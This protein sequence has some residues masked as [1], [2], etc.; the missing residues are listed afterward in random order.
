MSLAEKVRKFTWGLLSSLTMHGVP[1]MLGIWDQG[2]VGGL[3]SRVDWGL[4][5]R[6]L[7]SHNKLSAFQYDH[8]RSNHKRGAHR[9]PG[10]HFMQ[11]ESVS[12]RIRAID[13]NEF[14]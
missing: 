6:Y 10:R 7:K 5:L 14:V 12:Y 1:N 8:H 2:H 13:S 4:E 11:Q 3:F 9:V